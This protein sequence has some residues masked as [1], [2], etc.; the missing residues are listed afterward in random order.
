MGV[1]EGHH[2]LSHHGG[3]ETKKQKIARINQYHMTQFAYF[4]EK[5]KSIPEGDGTLLD[6][7]MILYGCGISDGNRH[8][9]NDLPVLMAGRGGGTVQTGRHV[10][11]DR[12]T[13]LNNLYLSMLDRMGAPAG[14]LGDSTG[15]VVD[16]A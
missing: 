14:K 2:T 9:H 10:R 16:L 3:D 4:L 6:N 11:F 7:S 5:L 13:P 1:H 15:R 8:N 12:Q